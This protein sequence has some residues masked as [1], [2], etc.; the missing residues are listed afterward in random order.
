MPKF[1]FENI[2]KFEKY[3][4][5]RNQKDRQVGLVYKELEEIFFIKFLKVNIVFQ[6]L[7]DRFHSC[8]YALYLR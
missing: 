2:N 6:Q 8:I 1:A 7:I 4:E 3:N 5:K